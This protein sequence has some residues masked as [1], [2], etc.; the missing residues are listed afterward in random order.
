VLAP[1]PPIPARGSIWGLALSL[2]PRDARE[3]VFVILTANYDESGTHDGSIATVLA[4]FAAGALEWEAFER[5]WSKI[6]RKHKIT[7]VRAKHLF[8]RQGQHKGWKQAKVREL[9]ADLLYVIQERELFASK[10][11]LYEQDYKLFYRSD[12]PARRERLDSRYALCFRTLLH[13]LPPLHCG[14]YVDSSVNFVLESGHRNSGDAKRVYDEMRE[15]KRFPWHKGIGFLTFGTK[16][17]SCALQAADMLAYTSYRTECEHADEPGEWLSDLEEELLNCKLTVVEHL[18]KPDD[19]KNM[20]KN[21][22][23]KNKVPVFSELRLDDNYDVEDSG[24]LPPYVGRR[25]Y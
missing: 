6:L 2:F 19:L 21:F 18:I 13:N 11:I 23:R 15:N 14:R 20:R 12:G 16:Q 4:G 3:R 10:T 8:H 22:L 17:S 25:Y 1:I 24:L 9:W 5:E 7:H